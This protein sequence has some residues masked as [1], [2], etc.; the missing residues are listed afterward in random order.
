MI[1]V[2]HSHGTDKHGHLWCC[3]REKSCPFNEQLLGRQ[4]VSGLDVVAEP[5]KGWLENS[6]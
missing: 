2:E 4:H 6:E 5:V 1:R 3:Q